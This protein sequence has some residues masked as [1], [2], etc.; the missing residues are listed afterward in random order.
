MIS[1]TGFG[2]IHYNNKSTAK[3]TSSITPPKKPSDSLA[4]NNAEVFTLAFFLPQEISINLSDCVIKLLIFY[5][6]SHLN[7]IVTMSL[8]RLLFPLIF[9]SLF[10]LVPLVFY[11]V[12]SLIR[13]L[14]FVTPNTNCVTGCS[15]LHSNICHTRKINYDIDFFLLWFLILLNCQKTLCIS[16]YD[17]CHNL[18]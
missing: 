2:N 8:P 18:V 1:A 12:L 14:G 3:M 17:V 6:L 9:P 13:I 5:V 7:G 11:G 16:H 10:E 4:I 15:I